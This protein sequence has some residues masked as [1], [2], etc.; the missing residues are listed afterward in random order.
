MS[1]FSII[2]AH[3]LALEL[4]GEVWICFRCEREAL[5]YTHLTKFR[6]QGPVANPGLTMGFVKS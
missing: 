5:G 1:A 3:Y 4:G 6:H 2:C